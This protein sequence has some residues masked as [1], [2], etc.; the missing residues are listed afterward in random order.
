MMMV[1]VI[2]VMMMTV[3]AMM[4]VAMIVMMANEVIK[5]VVMI[6][7]ITRCVES[8]VRRRIQVGVE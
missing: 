8:C 4:D 1:E 3:Q 5:M 6:K 7:S 2:T